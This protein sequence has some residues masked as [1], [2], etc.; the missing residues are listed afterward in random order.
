[1]PLI[2]CEVSLTLNWSKNSPL[3]D[4]IKIAAVPAQGDNPA[5]SSIAAPTSTTFK[6]TDTKLYAPAITLT[7]VNDN[8]LLEQLKIGFKRRAKWSKYR[9]ELS[10]ETKNSILNHLIDPTFSNV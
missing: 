9:S 2:D 1:M 6:I 7:A 10:N 5:R 3:T 4:L 8:K